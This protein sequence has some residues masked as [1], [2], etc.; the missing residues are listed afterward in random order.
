MGME[1]M[2]WVDQNKR[3]I[4]DRHVEGYYSIGLDMS[5]NVIA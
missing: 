4:I 5:R 3:K 1:G 2:G